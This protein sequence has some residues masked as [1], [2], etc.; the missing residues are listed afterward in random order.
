MGGREVN[1]CKLPVGCVGAGALRTLANTMDRLS[2][3]HV[4]RGGRAPDAPCLTTIW[5]EGDDVIA[6]VKSGDQSYR[7]RLLLSGWAFE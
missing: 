6:R 3:Y 5:V 4:G 2:A 7:L 1:E